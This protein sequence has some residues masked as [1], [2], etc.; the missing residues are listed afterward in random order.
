MHAENLKNTKYQAYFRDRRIEESKNGP[1]TQ[2]ET[3][4]F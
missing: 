3:F 1:N 4:F 2:N